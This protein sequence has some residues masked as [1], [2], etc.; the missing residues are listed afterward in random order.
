MT[1]FEGALIGIGV[2]F[3]LV[4]LLQ[5]WFS[6]PKQDGIPWL[7]VAGAATAFVALIGEDLA[8][9]ILGPMVPAKQALLIRAF[10]II[11]LIE[12]CAK[13]G[14]IYGRLIEGDIDTFGEF[15]IVAAF[16]A[17]GF[18]SVEN[19]LYI[20]KYGPGV[21]FIRI[22]TATPFHICN[23]VVAA[24]LLWVSRKERQTGHWFVVAAIVSAIFLHGLYDYSILA[25]SI[26]DGKF[27]FALMMTGTLAMNFL[28]T[29]KTAAE[30]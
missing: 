28:R 8:W 4:A 23:A 11:A 13:T 16:I 6:I 1:S 14:L 10:L 26:G 2:P 25:D 17:A 3:L 24:K 9:P 27:W 22:F 12:E 20:I 5:R 30:G 15:A 18:A 19:S 7:C 21:V 29:Q